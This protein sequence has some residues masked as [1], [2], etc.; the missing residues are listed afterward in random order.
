M[1]TIAQAALFLLTVIEMLLGL[2]AGSMAL[3]SLL[4]E[5]AARASSA[6]NEAFARHARLSPV[7]PRLRNDVASLLFGAAHAG[8]AK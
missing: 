5:V 2:V 1:R 6:G 4:T 3:A 7:T 8:G